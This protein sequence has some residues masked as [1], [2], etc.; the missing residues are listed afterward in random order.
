MFKKQVIILKLILLLALLVTVF[1][2]FKTFNPGY[3]LTSKPA[4][5]LPPPIPKVTIDSA[6]TKENDLSRLDNKKII[7]LI[8]TGDVIPARGA[9]WPAVTSGDFTYNWRKTT[10]TIKKGDITL[11]DLEA[12]LLKNCPLQ[13]EGFTFCGDARHVQGLVFA[14]VDVASLANNHIGNYGQAGIDETVNLLEGNKIAWSGFSHLAIVENKKVKF[15][16]LAYNGIGTKFDR[17]A[18]ASEIKSAKT[19]VDILVVSAHWGDEY[20]LTPG[21]YGNVAPDDP[22]E[23]GH[24]MIDAGAD[25][26]IGNH[27]H[28]VQGVE[29]FRG[30]LITYAHGNFIFDQTWSQETQEGVVGE[31]TFYEKQ[32]VQVKFLP[33]LVDVSYQ[34]RFLSK[35]DGQPI[36]DRMLKSSNLISEN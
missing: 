6:F 13:T 2:L 11:I 24:L 30:K 8:A 14:G 3:K 15:G 18:I 5:K 36:L 10:D 29:I 35:K 7:T 16:F 25:L 27:P 34:P 28:T 33:I 17:E 26:V 20:V 23:I 21:K 12:P 32:L 31:Y 9:N 4:T 22:R 19:K 1:A